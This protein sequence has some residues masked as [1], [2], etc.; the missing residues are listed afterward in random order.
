MQSMMPVSETSPNEARPDGYIKHPTP[1]QLLEVRKHFRRESIGWMLCTMDWKSYSTKQIA[2]ILDASE[3]R[4]KGVL[5]DIRKRFGVDIPHKKMP[6]AWSQ[7]WYRQKRR[8][9]GLK[10]NRIIHRDMLKEGTQ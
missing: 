1:E 9:L 6:R 10:E 3:S 8:E 5:Y 2:Y 7:T 4:V